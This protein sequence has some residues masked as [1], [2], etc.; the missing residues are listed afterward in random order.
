[1][2]QKVQVMINTS[3]DG[4]DWWSPDSSEAEHEAAKW[5]KGTQ[6]LL[7]HCCCVYDN[8]W[9]KWRAAYGQE[10]ALPQCFKQILEICMLDEWF[11][12]QTGS[13]GKSLKHLLEIVL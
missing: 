11:V 5:L 7:W 13:Q 6:S 2:T 1:M 3:T 9:C 12:I 4:T 8:W 10:T